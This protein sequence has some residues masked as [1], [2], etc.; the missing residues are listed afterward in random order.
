METLHEKIGDVKVLRLRGRLDLEAAPEF[1]KL[2]KSLIAGGETRIILDCQDLKYVSS[3]G[4][5][6]FIA[7]GKQLA[8]GG[9]LVF[10]GLSNNIESLFQMTGISGLF[11]ICKTRE[12]A[13]ARFGIS[14]S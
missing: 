6:A 10:S 7:C 1:E 2:L 5:G 9:S 12:D 4:L 14:A 8:P 13:L 11:L 3:S